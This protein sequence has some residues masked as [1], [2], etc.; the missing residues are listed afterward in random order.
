[1]TSSKCCVCAATAGDSRT[2]ACTI[3]LWPGLTVSCGSCEVQRVRGDAAR[4]DRIGLVLRRLVGDADLIAV[5][6]VAVRQHDIERLAD[7]VD[8]TSKLRAWR[9]CRQGRR[10]SAPA[11]PRNRWFSALP[12]HSRRSRCGRGQVLFRIVADQATRKTERIHDVL[13]ASMHSPH[14]MHL[15]CR[16]SRMSMPTGQTCT[17][18]PQSTQSPR[19]FSWRSA[20]VRWPARA[21]ARRVP[22]RR[23]WHRKHGQRLGLVHHALEAAI[24]AD[25]GADLLA[26]QACAT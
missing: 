22:L 11:S 23:A 2:L 20:R 18:R 16:P 7:L 1:M 13:Q 14:E 15:Y 3:P 21:V 10:S 6:D 12:L 9:R 26:H 4:A 8:G 25:I 5:A 17:H 19:P 24:G